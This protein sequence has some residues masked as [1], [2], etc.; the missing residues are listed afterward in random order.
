MENIK[1]LTLGEIV[2]QNYKAAAVLEKFQLDFCCKGNQTV[3]EACQKSGLNPTAVI[4]ELEG[5]GKEGG[6]GVNFDEWPLHVL[7]DHIV[8]K[9]H[10]Y[11]EE[12]T[13]QI[14]KYLDKI[15]QVHGGRHPELFEIRKIFF[16][17]GGE[18]TVHMKKEEL[19]LFPFIKK[20]EKAK[21]TNEVAESP[22]FKSVSS[23][24]EMM[25]ADHAEEGEKL[26]RI[27]ALT[28]NYSIP[29]DAC[30][31]F[32]VTYQLLNDY[33]KDLHLHIHLE[34]NILFPKAIAMEGQLNA[35][36]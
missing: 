35:V 24:V 30:N 6:D 8:R 28:G 5:V 36:S 27:A 31:T 34:N 25:K 16:E 22:L 7:V 13:P 29:A 23:P 2:K 12:Q 3:D 18:L 15:C 21:E 4:K 14:K 33:E 17:V 9:H 11:I 1:T 19:M 32:A 20:I 26:A 10:G